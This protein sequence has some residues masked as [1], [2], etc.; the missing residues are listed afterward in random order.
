MFPTEDFSPC[1]EVTGTPLGSSFGG[2]LVGVEEA[3][4]EAVRVIILFGVDLHCPPP[5]E[6]EKSL[7][8]STHSN[9]NYDNGPVGLLSGPLI[10]GVNHIG[11]KRAIVDHSFHD[12]MDQVAGPIGSENHE[13]GSDHFNPM[14]II[15]HLQFKWRKKQ[16][17]LQRK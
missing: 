5:P 12:Q 6:M 9:V 13:L 15:E 7:I 17:R 10:A 8:P 16:R 3:N 4:N 14:P 11:H 1:L 2:D